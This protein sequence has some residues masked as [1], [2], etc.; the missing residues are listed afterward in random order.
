MQDIPSQLPNCSKCGQPM[1]FLESV[2][3]EGRGRK[4][5]ILIFT[6][7]RDNEFKRVPLKKAP[8]TV[9]MRASVCRKDPDSLQMQATID[10]KDPDVRSI[11]SESR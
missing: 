8:D 4:V 3:G 2:E 1:D 7:Y 11:P 6:C 10:K 5:T 9:Q